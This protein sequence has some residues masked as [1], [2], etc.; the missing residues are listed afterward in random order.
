MTDVTTHTMKF[1]PNVLII[2]DN[3]HGGE[4]RIENHFRNCNEEE[5]PLVDLCNDL[6]QALWEDQNLLL[7]L[8]GKS[9]IIYSNKIGFRESIQLRDVEL[10]NPFLRNVWLENVK[11]N[12]SIDTQIWNSKLLNFTPTQHYY[13]V[14]VEFSHISGLFNTPLEKPSLN[15]RFNHFE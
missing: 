13:K 8:F 7:V 9:R 11:I 2:T 1:E 10:V 15:L 4:L 5:N 3:V 14:N 12:S 6:S